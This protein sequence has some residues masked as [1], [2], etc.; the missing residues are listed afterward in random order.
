MA[1]MTR[2]THVALW[3]VQWTLAALFLFAGGMKLVTPLADLAETAAPLS[4]AFLK[5][6]GL[7]EVA[8]ALGLVLPGL[9]KIRE[10]L[11]ALAA[12]GLALLMVGAVILVIA[13]HGVVPAATPFA[14][15]VLAVV[16]A[17][18]RGLFHRRRAGESSGERVEPEGR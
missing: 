3:I 16:V 6:I 1:A 11:T 7:C 10:G 13:T 15:G 8:G 12:A 4:A 14:V 18:G 2:R 9:L 17:R 5:F